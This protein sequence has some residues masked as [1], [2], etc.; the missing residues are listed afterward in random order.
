MTATVTLGIGYAALPD[1]VGTTRNVPIMISVAANDLGFTDPVT[2]VI[3]TGPDA[4]GTVE[5][6]GSPGPASGLSFAYTPSSPAGSPSYAETFTYTITGDNGNVD[7]ATVTVNVTNRQPALD[8]WPMATY[9]GQPSPVTRLIQ[10][11]TLGDGSL[12]DHEVEVTAQGAH[13]PAWPVRRA[14]SLVHTPSDDVFIG[15][16]TCE[17]TLTDLDG[18]S[19]V[20]IINITVNEVKQVDAKI[21]GAGTMGP[22]ACCC[23]VGCL[24]CAAVASPAWRRSRCCCPVRFCRQDGARRHRPRKWPGNPPGGLPSRRSW[25]RPAR[26][27]NP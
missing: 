26:S 11:Y 2:V 27:R 12:A 20:D 8:V 18:E 4:G 22:G 17:L 15:Q 3:D 9:Q 25:S 6:T 5:V 23:S 7:T 13:V 19:T 16:D 1:I 21:G 10:F 24:C 14:G